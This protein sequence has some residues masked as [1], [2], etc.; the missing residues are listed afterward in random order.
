MSAKSARPFI[1]NPDAKYDKLALAADLV[2]QAA[3]AIEEAKSSAQNW[4]DFETMAYFAAQLQEFMS[5][6]HGEAG[7]LAYLGRRRYPVVRPDGRSVMVSVP[8]D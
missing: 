3:C 6:D 1:D 2:V 4:A 7:F 5:S 8:T